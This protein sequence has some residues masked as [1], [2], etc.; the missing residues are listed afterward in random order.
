M[1]VLAL[2][3][4]SARVELQRVREELE[5]EEREELERG[6]GGAAQKLFVCAQSAVIPANGAVEHALSTVIYR[7]CL[8]LL[9][10]VRITTSLV[11]Y[12][13]AGAVS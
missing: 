5:L 11:C 1:L 8:K 7:V 12:K 10:L 13:M 4:F 3:G 6:A 9:L 2:K